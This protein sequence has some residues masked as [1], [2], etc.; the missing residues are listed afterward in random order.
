MN[1]RQLKFRAW[2]IHQKKWVDEALY[3]AYGFSLE[4]DGT[5]ITIDVGDSIIQQ[6]T[7]LLDK[8][9]KEIYEGDIVASPQRD[10]IFE[11]RHGWTQDEDA[12]GWLFISKSRLGAM[13]IDKA[14]QKIEVI[15]NLFENPELLK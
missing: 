15:G 11:V 12:Y 10:V 14:H 5:Q 13:S 3:G 4:I 9:G 1:Q 6:F 8:N 2:D 7:G